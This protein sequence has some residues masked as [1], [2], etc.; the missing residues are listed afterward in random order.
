MK[1]SKCRCLNVLFLFSG[2]SVGAIPQQFTYYGS[3]T[4]LQLPGLIYQRISVL[5][6][7]SE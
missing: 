2:L 5:T 4:P 3:L 7:T 6:G 1:Q